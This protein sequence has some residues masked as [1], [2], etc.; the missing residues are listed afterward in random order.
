[1]EEDFNTTRDRAAVERFAMKSLPL[2]ENWKPGTPVCT[3]EEFSGLLDAL[4]KTV[5]NPMISDL[6]YFLAGTPT[7]ITERAA[8]GKAL[9]EARVSAEGAEHSPDMLN[10][11]Q[12]NHSEQVLIQPGELKQSAVDTLRALCPADDCLADN[13]LNEDWEPPV[14]FDTIDTP[15]FP[16]ESLPGPLADFVECLATSTQ[17]PEEMAGVLSL[18]VLATAFQS[19]YDVEV[20]PDWHEPLCLFTVAVAPPGERKSAV[21]SAL[22][23]PVF[24]YE[25]ERREAEAGEIA[26]NQTE[27]SMLESR[28]QSVK[29]AGA[30]ATGAKNKAKFEQCRAEAL[31]IS[32]ELAHFKDLHP[33]RLLVDDTTPE[34]LIDIM[35]AQNGCITVA[36]A[37]GGLFDSISGRYDKNANFDIY[38][39][40]HAGDTVTVDRIGRKS[41]HI[42][43]PRL[44]MMLTIQPEVLEGLM[45]NAAFRGRG[46]C[47][48]FLYA[49]CKSKVG[50][51]DISPDP[52]PDAV[53]TKYRQFVRTILSDQGR[54]TIQLSPEADKLRKEYAASIEQ[55]LGD[56]WEYMRDW[57]GKLVGAM[58][59]IAALMHAA[60]VQS[61]AADTPIPP[62]DVEAAMKIAEFFGA[63]AVAAYQMMGA[64]E[65]LEDARYLWRRIESTGQEEIRKRDLWHICKGKF[66]RVEEMEPALQVLTEMGYIRVT[67]KR[68]N[69]RPTKI[70]TVN[71][72]AES[73][74][75][76]KAGRG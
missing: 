44:T 17:T 26:R 53:K 41:N 20:T 73:G 61:N 35:D 75:K 52:I 49:I 29:A 57:G 14:P 67:E 27:R 18:G 1:M 46:L 32:D 21:I 71:P 36:S 66:E 6:L 43:D 30:K 5:D 24:E 12:A 38:L 51:R 19:K 58:V 76:A 33:F 37:E 8:R 40:G 4:G 28:L 69:G 25:A 50:H 22:T 34:K 68:T 45:Q 9:Y 31:E 64:S 56:E 39:K 70:L 11:I 42:Q 65:G 63:H 16:T 55:R 2:A 62:E 3:G 23:R 54:G 48:R 59:R 7:D 15:N 47:G 60:E 72:K 13:D 10:A 74:K